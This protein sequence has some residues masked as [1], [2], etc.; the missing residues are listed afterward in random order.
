M[1]GVCLMSVLS[2]TRTR[3]SRV[4]G[5]VPTLVFLGLVV[6]VV[7]SLGAPL[8]PAVAEVHHVALVD[9]QWSL[10]VTLV[11]GAMVTPVM[12]RLGDG[13]ARRTVI[14]AGLALVVL[15]CVLAALPLGFAALL[16]GRAVQGAG[17]GLTPLTIATARD[18]LEPAK[19]RPTMAMLSITT[20]A[21]V[22]LGYPV[23]GLVAE[24][25]GLPAAYWFGAAVAAV[26]LVAAIRVVPH[27][28]HLKRARL[29][30]PGAVLLGAGL[31]A[32]L[33]VISKGEEWGWFSGAALATVVIAVAAL[34]TWVWHER[35]SSHPL[36]DLRLL[37][38]PGVLAADVAALLSG[39]GM[40]LLV[41]LIV[42]FVQ[43][44]P[45]AGGL[46]GSVVV[47]GLVLLPFSIG[48]LLAGRIAPLF[49]RRGRTGVLIPGAAVL[50]LVSVGVF[51]FVRHDYAVLAVVMTVT[52]LS[53]GTV[54]AVMP[55][56]I[57]RATPPH[58]TGSAMSFNQV[59]R[60]VGYATGSALSAAILAAHTPAG[61][62]YPETS[63]YAIAAFAGVAVWLLTGVFGI[64]LPGRTTPPQQAEP[65]GAA[66]QV[67][68]D[69]S[70]AD[71]LPGDEDEGARG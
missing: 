2:G 23:T 7:S 11:V 30:V 58:E 69:E 46:G 22:G 55:G 17:L 36:V 14:L 63:G 33:L 34:V 71:G 66:E 40:Y 6:A 47:A 18:A 70:V 26:A 12:G 42:Q 27:A 52:G 20:V 38:F 61:Q 44:P 41:S 67:L 62:R 50:A 43:T 68:V 37:R 15:G 54:F 32:L 21:G 53:V 57:T 25:G 31:G 65:T 24:F 64:L 60:Y 48:S 51:G 4:R 16:A 29:D 1:T 56:M 3:P 49:I 13:S 8:I 39:T 5:L 45:A 28:R 9:A 35:R 10:T 19:A 59:L